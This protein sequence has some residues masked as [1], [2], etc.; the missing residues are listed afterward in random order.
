MSTSEWYRLLASVAGA[1]LFAGLSAWFV[2]TRA[3]RTLT[4]EQK[5]DR[6]MRRAKSERIS[7][8]SVLFI[9]FSG[10]IGNC[11]GRAVVGIWVK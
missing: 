6:E 4:P 7:W 11:I 10:A 9:G 1:G 8:G 3:L 5:Q 2:Q